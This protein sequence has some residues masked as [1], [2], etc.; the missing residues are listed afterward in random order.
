MLIGPAFFAA[1]LAI[2]SP[3]SGHRVQDFAHVLPPRVA[4]ELE[5]L[6]RDMDEKTTAEL[7]VVTV[8]SLE[9]MTVEDYANKLFNQWGIGKKDV[10]NGVLLLVA[11]KE[12]R[13]RIEVGYGLE[14][15]LTDGLCGEIRDEEIIPYFKRKDYATGIEK[16]ARA[17]AGILL[18][19]P[20]AARGV[21]GSAPAFVT[22]PSGMIRNYFMGLA[23]LA[24]LFLIFGET[25]RWARAYPSMLFA[26]GALVVGASAVGL[27]M[28]TFSRTDIV[29][30]AGWIFAG[31]GGVIV[32]LFSNARRYMRFGPH[33]CRKCGTRLELL[34]EKK[35][36]AHL[37]LSQKMEEELGSVDYD[38]WVCP[39]C[40][41]NQTEAYVATFSGMSKCP[42]CGYR[43]Y[44]EIVTVTVSPTYISTGTRRCDGRCRSCLFEDTRYEVIP[45]MS[46]SSGGDSGGSSGGGGDF[47]GGSSGGGGASGGW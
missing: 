5:T 1:L 20:D 7:A 14:P 10:N 24:I 38:V 12:R 44:H 45:V 17:I 3:V 28:Y 13:M 42:K 18:A 34:D 36:D 29:Y 27:T 31:W 2:P 39:A 35:D 21:A 8:D 15:L 32:A 40:M 33:Q 23:A 37:N 19:N 4:A 9:G 25:M 43:T 16:G 6:S 30:P 26:V 47:G 46:R 22:T 11:M 41:E